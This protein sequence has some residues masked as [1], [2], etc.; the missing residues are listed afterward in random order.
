MTKT[1]V[2]H[3]WTDADQ[4]CAFALYQKHGSFR[5]VA[6]IMGR[7]RSTVGDNLRGVRGRHRVLP[8]EKET[9]RIPP[10]VLAD[11]DR[12]RDLQPQDYT[13]EFFGDPLPG[14]SALDR[15]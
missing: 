12:R 10:E 2:S 3:P 7:N 1:R 13:A 11:R 15:R 14:Y 5:I 4:A 9:A 8:Q 6:G